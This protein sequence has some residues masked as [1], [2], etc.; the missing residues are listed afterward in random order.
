MAKVL[1]VPVEDVEGLI[2]RP[3][4]ADDLDKLNPDFKQSALALSERGYEKFQD[5]LDPEKSKE[6][7]SEERAFLWQDLV[8]EILSYSYGE[9]M[10]RDFSPDYQK[11]LID[12]ST[13]YGFNFVG[14]YISNRQGRVGTAYGVEEISAKVIDEITEEFLKNNPEFEPMRN[15]VAGAARRFAESGMNREQIMD[16]LNQGAQRAAEGQ[17]LGLAQKD[18]EELKEAGLDKSTVNAIG[19]SLGRD[20]TPDQLTAL[21]DLMRDI[22]RMR[23]RGWSIKWTG[24]DIN[25]TAQ[26]DFG[27]KVIYLNSDNLPKSDKQH[28]ISLAH[29]MSHLNDYFE[30]DYN[31]DRV[32]QVE[33]EAKA[34]ARQARIE[35]ILGVDS[36][37]TDFVSKHI[38]DMSGR[39][40]FAQTVIGMP[41]GGANAVIS[42]NERLVAELEPDTLE[43][44]GANSLGFV[45]G[46]K[47]ID[48]YLV[49]MMPNGDRDQITFALIG[50]DGKV[51]AMRRG[52]EVFALDPTLEA[53]AIDISSLIASNAPMMISDTNATLS[54][55]GIVIS[56]VPGMIERDPT[57]PHSVID[58]TT[59]TIINKA[60][61][62]IKRAPNASN[63]ALVLRPGD[64]TPQL[65][66]FLTTEKGKE[67]LVIKVLDDD[68][69]S[70]DHIKTV[71]LMAKTAA[72]VGTVEFA[73]DYGFEV[74]GNAVSFTLTTLKAFIK[75]LVQAVKEAFELAKAA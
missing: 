52:A 57:N 14:D 18:L 12:L 50:E 9:R 58:A 53:E 8:S 49:S 6:L 48:G 59:D 67:L 23:A 70:E 32:N 55:Q 60:L 7:S 46:G 2:T 36:K 10:I 40:L 13:D 25:R 33:S 63:I 5:I 22:K 35:K 64:V 4:T 65:A 73:Q 61:A 17:S 71:D 56:M 31:L 3:V 72:K 68:K 38:R 44:I 20:T 34:Y 41:V 19:N 62:A 66:D 16:R 15:E 74:K 47:E 26:T 45:A 42:A 27:N 11:T 39:G 54:H 24:F 1:G 30:A 43:Y 51:Y 21:R 28:V 69:Y 37:I 75:S 29:E